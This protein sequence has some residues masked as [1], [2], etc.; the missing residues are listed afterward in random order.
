M[1]NLIRKRWFLL[2]E[3]ASKTPRLSV[4]SKM[5]LM[6]FAFLCRDVSLNRI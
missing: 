1:D 5:P 2:F 6:I 4:K 3:S